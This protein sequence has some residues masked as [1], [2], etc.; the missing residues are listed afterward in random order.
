MATFQLANLDA[1]LTYL[2]LQYH[3][4]RPGSEI[5]P[6]TRQPAEHGLREVAHTLEPQLDRAVSTIELS[7]YQRDRLASAVAGALNQLKAYPLLAGSRST[8]PGF[9]AALKRLF[10]DVAADPDEATSLAGHLVALRRRLDAAAL[11]PDERANGGP[12]RSWRFWQR[13]A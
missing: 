7:E 1:R 2:A 13:G 6:D 9:D 11:P 10:P 8:A 5:D 3:L 12:K 4:A